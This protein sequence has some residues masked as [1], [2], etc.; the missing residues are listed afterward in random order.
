MIDL[1]LHLDGSLAPEDVLRLAQLTNI[2]LP[3]ED[4]DSLRPLLEVTPNCRNLGEYLEKFDLPLQV[5][6]KDESIE[7]SV[8]FLLKRLSEQGL[9]YAEIRFA[10]QLHLQRGLTQQ[11]VVAAAVNGLERGIAEFHMPAQLILC[12]MRGDAN[13]TANLETVRVA[14]A[15][16]GHGVC[17]VDLAGNEAAYPTEDFFPVFS[18]A[19]ELDLPIII[20][21]GEAAG[22]ESVRQALMLNARRIGHGV[23]SVE[24]KELLNLLAETKTPLELCYTSNLQTKAVEDS[25]YPICQLLDAGI[26]ITINTDNMT[27]SGTNLRREYT[28]L[29][30]AFG[31]SENTLQEIACNAADAA[32]VPAET[33][34]KLKAQ[35]AQN[36][37]NWLN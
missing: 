30:D 9:C 10:P 35:I 4:A 5:L 3:R 28:L 15:F 20:H 12:C 32:F 13:E 37:K 24:N 31:L 16:L 19:E 34:E 23:R 2:R 22:A 25:A 11:Q 33:K 27:V 29:R 36:F 14:K 21:A 8:Y 1:H 7:L 17:A 26:P 18:L 6:Q